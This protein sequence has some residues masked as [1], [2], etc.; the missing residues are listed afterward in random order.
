MIVMGL[1]GAMA[2]GMAQG[3]RPSVLPPLPR[4]IERVQP[5][6]ADPGCTL[7]GLTPG[8]PVPGTWRGEG[9][10]RI[11]RPGDQVTMDFIEGRRNIHLDRHGNVVRVTCG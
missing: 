1:L 10:V 3:D 11:I 9:R 2:T 6:E 7:A 4:A 8:K 5:V